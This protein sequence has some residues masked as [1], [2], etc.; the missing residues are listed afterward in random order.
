MERSQSRKRPLLAALL[1]ALA[2]GLGHLYLRRWRRA[3]GW[4][5]ALF[6]VSVLFVDPAAFEAAGQGSVDPLALAPLLLVATLSVLDAYA[7]AHVHNA[8]AQL[9]V[10]GDGQLTH[11]PNCGRELD[12]DI[13]F[14]HWCTADVSEL[15]VVATTDGA[16]SESE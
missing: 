13:E 6:A 14:C 5:V 2:T 9:S 10:T 4:L 3:L 1:G 11:C 16:G 15:D 7:L 12:P 8:V